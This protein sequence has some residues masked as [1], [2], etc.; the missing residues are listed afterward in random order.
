MLLEVQTSFHL[1]LHAPSSLPLRYS[2][3][4]HF[5]RATVILWNRS[6]S[7]SRH[8]RRIKHNRKK[9]LIYVS[10]GNDRHAALRPSLSRYISLS[11]CIETHSRNDSLQLSF[12][13]KLGGRKRN[14]DVSA[15]ELDKN[16]G[17]S[18]G[19]GFRLRNYGGS[20]ASIELTFEETAAG[21]RYIRAHRTKL[22]SWKKNLAWYNV[23]VNGV[24]IDV[25]VVASRVTLWKLEEKWFYVNQKQVY[26]TVVKLFHFKHH[27]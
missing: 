2:H 23:I 14:I 4:C 8:A 24:I 11:E 18:K 12:S 26:G 25:T 5:S 16:G 17:K 13:Q 22:I 7:D 20:W 6:N 10:S 9:K 21:T 3:S 1:Q 19:H 15:I 27:F